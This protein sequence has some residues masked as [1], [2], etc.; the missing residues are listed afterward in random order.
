MNALTISME[1]K[2]IQSSVTL[3]ITSFLHSPKPS[4]AKT[5][6]IPY[7]ESIVTKELT[8]GFELPTGYWERQ[9]ACMRTI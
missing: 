4:M 5:V 3:N 7:M 6:P 1:T 8:I 2:Q 9:K